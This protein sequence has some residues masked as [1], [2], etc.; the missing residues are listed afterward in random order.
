MEFPGGMS[1]PQS[2]KQL[3]SLGERP[4]S[5]YPAVI[6]IEHNEWK[7]HK[8][9]WSEILVINT[10]SGNEIW[11]PRRFLGEISRVDEPVMI[12]GL[13]RELEY[14]AGSL[15]PYERRIIEMPKAV[16]EFAKPSEESMAPPPGMLGW[17]RLDQGNDWKFGK[18]ILGLLAAGIL[19]CFVL[20]TIIS[21]RNSGKNVEYVSVEQRSLGLLWNDDFGGVVRKLGQPTEDRWRSGQGSLQ[22]R[23]MSY[24]ERKL[25]V[26]LMGH[27]RDK[28]R[29]IGAMDD[30]WRVVDS[31]EL[32]SSGNTRSM[33]RALQKF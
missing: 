2:P 18:L 24:P 12:V 13:K 20:V 23:L 25:N 10:K 32:P 28:A 30:Q 9:S 6:N 11:V 21:N 29:Y 15:F 5:F 1:N 14:K 4:F 17:V 8:S 7:C 3:E 19:I 16:N 26:I 33:L 31:V 22:Y 27:E